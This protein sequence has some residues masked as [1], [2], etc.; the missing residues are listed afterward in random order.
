MPPSERARI[1]IIG[2]GIA[3]LTAAYDL[4]EAGHRVTIY[5][6]APEVGGLAA[7][8][9]APHWEWSL[10]KFYHH[11]FASDSHILGFIDKLGWSDQVVFQR[12]YTVVYFD[13]AFHPLD[14]YAE[15]AKFTTRHFGVVDLVRFGIVGMYLKLTPRWQPLEQVTADAWMRKWVGPRVYE[16]LWRPL[17]VGKFGEENLDVVNMA[18]MWARIKARTTR[19]GTFQG[20]FQAFVEKLSQVLRARRVDI[21]LN[22]AVLRVCRPPVGQ[23]STLVVETTAGGEAYSAVISTSSP[24]LMARIVPELP[25]SYARSLQSLKSMGAVVLVVTLDRQLSP[26]YWHNL[27]K[28]AGFPFLALVEHTNFIGP[29]HYGGDHIIYCGDYLQPDHE[30]F[31]LSKEELLDRFLPSFQRINPQ[32]ERSWVKDVWLWKTAYA[33]PIPPV[34][35]SQ[36]V[37]PLRTPLPGLYFASMSQVYPW[38][39]GTNFAVEIGQK[40]AGMVIED[41]RRHVTSILEDQR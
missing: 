5:E 35:H 40:V 31:R 14:S 22:T 13:G 8:F 11:W 41:L 3:G 20:G 24:A 10:E 25:A 2:A 32:F 29:E 16:A 36:N 28:E 34:N 12:P 19:L 17:L 9:R 6:A 38:D 4:T 39:R 30:Y 18:W 33:Q 7:G 23:D 21:R 15:A 27:P 1:G 37:P 26:Y